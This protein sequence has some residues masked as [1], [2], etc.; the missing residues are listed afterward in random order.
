MNKKLSDFLFVF[1]ICLI[2]IGVVAGVIAGI[3]FGDD[4]NFAP[5][6]TIWLLSVV[7]GTGLISVSASVSKINEKKEDEQETLRLIIERIK[8]DI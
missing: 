7:V 5:A 3:A 6:V 4:F 1:G 8:D 2:I